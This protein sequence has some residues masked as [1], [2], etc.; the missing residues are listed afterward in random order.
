[1]RILSNAPTVEDQGTFG[2][3]YAVNKVRRSANASRA[4]SP[5]A[6]LQSGNAQLFGEFLSTIYHISNITI[7]FF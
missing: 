1:M 3:F 7:D 6:G 4:Y 5:N 2:V